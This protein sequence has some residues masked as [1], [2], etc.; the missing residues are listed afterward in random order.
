MQD[1]KVGSILSIPVS[2][3]A[4]YVAHV[5]RRKK[6]FILVAAF[7]AAGVNGPLGA[8]RLVAMTFDSLVKTGD[9]TIVGQRDPDP[10]IPIPVFKVPVSSENAVYI[11][12]LDGHLWRLATAD[13]AEHL[14]NPVTYSAAAFQEA[15]NQIASG[16]SLDPEF[17]AMVPD[18]K[19]CEQAV[20]KEV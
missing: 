18:P 1:L 6:G 4:E 5:I 11:Q 2:G 12:D 9:W 10:T 17:A 8:P 14:S 16:E 3:T 15:V 20:L 13:E 19:Y 7:E